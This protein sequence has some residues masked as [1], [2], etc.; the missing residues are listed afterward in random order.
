MLVKR[1]DY[2]LVFFK[3]ARHANPRPERNFEGSSSYNLRHIFLKFSTTSANN[4]VS[5]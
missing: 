4:N 3:A 2:S 1:P 5:L